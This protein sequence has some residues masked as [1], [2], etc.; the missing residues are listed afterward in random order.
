MIELLNLVDHPGVVECSSIL[1]G[2][3]VLASSFPEQY[4]NH[5]TIAKQ[6]FNY[7]FATAAKMKSKHDEAHLEIGDKRLSGFLLKGDLILVC[8]SAKDSNIQQVR[9]Q[10]RQASAKLLKDEL[11]ELS[12]F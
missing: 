12:K 5:A 9:K 3:E 11:E 2:K 6:S 10:A 7:V 1:K 4:K 8:L